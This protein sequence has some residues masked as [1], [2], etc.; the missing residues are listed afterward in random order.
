MS[1]GKQSPYETP[2]LG[3]A[4]FSFSSRQKLNLLFWLLAALQVATIGAGLF[5]AYRLQRQ[6]LHT[7]QFHERWNE[8][9]HKV[10][11]LEQLVAAA[12]PPG[13]DDLD[14]E[15]ASQLQGRMHYATG[16]FVDFAGRL[17]GDLKQSH[18]TQ[19]E[20]I[21][22]DVASLQ[23]NM[24]A[25][26]TQ[27]DQVFAA[28]ESGQRFSLEAQLTYADRAYR[29]V[30][31]SLGTL[32]QDLFNLEKES[33]Q[34][35][36]QV[37]DRVRV[38]QRG[39]ALSAIFVVA[40][41]LFYARVLHRQLHA[42][43]AA[44]R[45]QHDVL[46]QRVHKRTADLAQSNAALQAE[47]TERTRAERVADAASRAK[48]EFLANMSHEIRTPMNGIMG[49]TELALTTDLNPEQRDYLY[50]IKS[51]TDSLLAL[52]N[53]IL[54]FSKIEADKLDLE[55]IDFGLRDCLDETVKSISLRAHQKGLE[56]ICHALPD[57]PDSLQGD[58][59]RLRQIL[60]NL[61]GNAVKFTDQGEVVVTV[62]Q[63]SESE[64]ETVLHFAVRDTG[65]GIPED[66]QETVFAAFTQADNSMT[67]RYGGSGLGLTIC[68]RLVQMMGGRIWLDS[69]PG[70]GSTFHFTARFLLQTL[71][72]RRE[73]F[74]PNKLHGVRVLVVDDNATNRHVLEA[75]LLQW[76][77]RPT[78]AQNGP[79][80]LELFQAAEGS[81][82]PFPLVLLDAQMPDMDGFSV[83]EAI[84]ARL[85]ADNCS[86]LMLTSAGLRGDAARCRRLGMDGYLPKPIK[87]SDLLEAIQAVMGAPAPKRQ[88]R[89]LVTLHSLREGR[90]HLRVLLAE[91]NRV[92]QILTTRL[93]EKR[94]HSVVV[95]ATG[96]VALDA[97]AKESFDL[98][99][100]DVQMPDMNGFQATAAIRQHEQLSGG[101]LPI[102]AMTAHAMVGDK[103]RCLEAGMDAYLAKPVQVSDLFTIIDNF[104]P[105]QAVSPGNHSG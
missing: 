19:S 75:M 96:Q 86:I 11:E 21:L 12:A 76:G 20:S 37:A 30:L 22:A 101:H 48:S 73:G 100:M 32:R 61:L 99:L 53:D 41:M 80:A 23:E 56:L 33:L 40:A 102:I 43:A 77:M 65:I 68:S 98:A 66:K 9:R 42:H 92:N 38:W 74:S 4:P 35:Q 29:R 94:G 103:E 97:L 69:A 85:G 91:D 84:R 87:Q 26:V 50:T 63:E 18:D 89:P 93:L 2:K 71:P 15:D 24:R 8:R 78:V 28:R 52:I 64:T 34:Q 83:A 39:L 7:V 55:T 27:A 45:R 81:G 60:L 47:I 54:D 31:L 44:L 67:R 36:L 5:G 82:R 72:A 79:E 13:K 59:A 88:S 58:P 57:V 49:M 105:S 90:R 95:A 25:L 70:R 10:T 17:A 104:F 16:L 3:W 46:E 6:Y 14:A 51:S 62:E 1:G